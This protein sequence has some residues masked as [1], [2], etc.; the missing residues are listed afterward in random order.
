[1]ACPQSLGRHLK[2]KP[3]GAYCALNENRHLISFGLNLK[4]ENPDS[5]HYQFIKSYLEFVDI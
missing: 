2:G 1:M 3:F 5:G 4:S